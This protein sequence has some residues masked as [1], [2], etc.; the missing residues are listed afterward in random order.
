MFEMLLGHL[1]GDYLLQ[2]DWMAMNKS[3]NTWIGWF[4]A[5]AHCIIYTAT[6]CAFMQNF[7]SLWIVAV[8]LSHFFIDKFAF[9]WWYLKHIKNMD[10]HKYFDY[11]KDS[12]SKAEAIQAGFMSVIYTVTDNTMHLVLMW[13]AYQI[14]Y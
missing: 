5:L 12:S 8:F 4:A 7:D 6:V 1:V 9:G 10:T 14:L 3:K 13:G 11:L 2:N